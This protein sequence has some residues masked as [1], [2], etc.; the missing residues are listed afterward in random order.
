MPVIN[1]DTNAVNPAAIDVVNKIT[2]E[3]YYGLRLYFN[4]V[5]T[6]IQFETQ[7]ARDSFHK[8]LIDAMSKV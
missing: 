1:D 4:G 6:K 5:L 7:D 3:D 2:S 8:N